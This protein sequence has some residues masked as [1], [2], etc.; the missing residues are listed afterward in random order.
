V[1]TR[2]L[3]ELTGSIWLGPEGTSDCTDELTLSRKGAKSRAHGRKLRSTGTKA[4]TR[5][6]ASSQ[7]ALIRKLEARANDLE[8]KLGETLEQQ[9][10][11]SEVLQVI[12]SSPGELEP[13]FRAMLESAT[14]IC[15]ASFGNLLLSEG[16]GRAAAA[17]QRAI[18]VLDQ[19]SFGHRDLQGW[20][21]RRR[22]SESTP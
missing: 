22:I 12:S 3:L 1:P 10:A 2:V 11:T 7:A 20:L 9:T 8:K 6:A 16:V 21:R 13:V 14:R 19:R 15:E 17:R 5:V 18:D 4:R